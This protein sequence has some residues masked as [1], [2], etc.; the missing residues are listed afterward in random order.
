LVE[1]TVATK[2][3]VSADS[4]IESLVV[5]TL[6][7]LVVCPAGIV[8]VV[9]IVVKS[10]ASAV[11]DVVAIVIMVGT[12]L[13]LLSVMTNETSTPSVDGVLLMLTLG[14]TATAVSLAVEHLVT[15]LIIKV[16]KKS[17]IALFRIFI[18]FLLVD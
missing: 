6:I 2:L 5:G 12:V 1:V 3:K 16:N 10:V 9:F 17:F 4:L 14:L 11:P 7:V 13:T 15:K 18:F 8:I